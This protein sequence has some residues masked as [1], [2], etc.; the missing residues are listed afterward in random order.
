MVVSVGTPHVKNVLFPTKPI[1]TGHGSLVTDSMEILALISFL[2]LAEGR[3]RVNG[4]C[5]ESR[6]SIP[7]SQHSAQLDLSFPIGQFVIISH[8]NA[9]I[10]FLRG[11]ISSI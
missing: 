6:I 7:Q 1:T 10:Y 9:Q 8:F 4:L 11:R 5:Y 3:S 2:L